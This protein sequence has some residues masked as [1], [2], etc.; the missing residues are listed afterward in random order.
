MDRIEAM[1]Q[2]ESK[3][4]R[5]GTVALALAVC[6][7]IGAIGYRVGSDSQADVAPSPP[8][9]A[10]ADTIADPIAA[11]EAR[12]RESPGDSANWSA[13]GSAYF[14]SGR[15]DDA[16]GAFGKAAQIAPRAV[17][18]SALGE[19]RVMA[20]AHDPMPAAA[21][22][23]FERAITLDPRDPRARYF[24]AVKRDLSGNHAGAIDDWLALLADTPPGAAWETDLRR[25]I[26]Q[27]GKINKIEVAERLAKVAQP[28][29]DHPAVIP[30]IPG[31]SADDLRGAA[32]L[33]PEEQRRMAEGMVSR[34]EG[35]LRG[36]PANVEGWVMLM[37][38][39]MALDQPDKARQA[40]TQA[41]AANPGQGAML[42]DRAARL[43]IR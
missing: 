5:R 25:T 14:E 39:R 42:R 41:L 23:D 38:S 43:G 15:F 31:P 3:T 7:A 16:V 32:T 27:V 4:G 10:S 13:L 2:G 40:F 9:G 12:S 26:E 22:A 36:D 35:R 29:S 30:A 34:L 17:T 18:W 19:A 28:S 11:L 8:P 20:S 6:V 33:R 1:A 21:V 24:L 37:R